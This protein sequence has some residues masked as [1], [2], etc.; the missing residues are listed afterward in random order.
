MQI[1]VHIR[2][3]KWQEENGTN[4]GIGLTGRQ[5]ELKVKRRESS[6]ATADSLDLRGELGQPA[7][8]LDQPAQDFAQ[9]APVESNTSSADAAL[10]S[11]APREVA[12]PV[13]ARHRASGPAPPLADTEWAE[14]GTG[15]VGRATRELSGAPST[16]RRAAE[17]VAGADA[18]P[19]GGGSALRVRRAA[20]LPGRSAAE[21]ALVARKIGR[22]P[23]E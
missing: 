11:S 20:Q 5:R 21:G 15:S 4:S 3:R 23:I 19:H 22:K 16:G 18:P 12:P 1:K 6:Q 2:W 9:P 7:P 10:R 17:P 13:R 8:R 14:T